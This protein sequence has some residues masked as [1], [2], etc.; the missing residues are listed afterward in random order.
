[1]DILPTLGYGGPKLR[2]RA[3]LRAA[4][5][6]TQSRI[7][8]KARAFKQTIAAKIFGLA[9]FLLLLT[10]GLAGFLLW[11]AARME[12]TI[13]IVAHL[14]LPLTDSISS[15]DEFGL[16]RRLAFERWFG[17]LNA[18]APNQEIISEAKT[19]YDS[20]TVK[21]TDEFATARRI[22]ASYP[23]AMASRPSLVEARTLLDQIE[24]AY[25]VISARQREVLDLQRS[26]QREKASA[27]LNPLNEMQRTVQ[28]QRELLQDKVAELSAASV[29]AVAL[30]QRYVLW[31][32]IAA[33]ASTVLLGLVVAALITDRLTQP[34]RSLASAIR[35]VQKGNLNVQ[36][37]VRSTD[38]VGALTDSFNFFVRELRDKEQIKQTF[39]KYVDVQQHQRLSALGTMAAGLAHELN[40]PASANLRAATQLPHTLTTLQIQTLK[41]C[42]EKLNREQLVF[43]GR[44]QTDLIGRADDADLD[45]LAQSDLEDTIMNWLD[46][47]QIADSWRLAPMLASAGMNA[48][49]LARIREQVGD[50]LLS[51]ALN[52]LESAVTIARL[53]HTLK[54]CSTRVSE[55]IK[56]FKAYTY[57]DQSPVQ[58]LDVHE[59]LENTLI[60]LRHKLKDI[61]IKR[62]YNRDLPRITAF[63]SALN[64]VWT[65]LLNNAAEALAARSNGTICLRTGQEND[66][67]VV[68]IADDGPGVP[69]ELQARLFEPFFT[70]KNVGQGTGLGL[71]IARR[72]VVERHH[73]TI[74][75]VS[76][77]GD[78]RFRVHLPLNPA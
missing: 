3:E 26:G 66:Y 55:L 56:V 61:V 36:V 53:S 13:K 49:E 70:T 71:S 52:W 17:A 44:L 2:N 77:P 59:G 25:R 75:V 21:S 72:I 11:E 32:T 60:V 57:M 7:W 18:T 40:N 27:L 24:P 69:T 54:R 4:M 46:D 45:P 65:I 5:E 28:T 37:P 41:L 58:E 47:A 43:L 74:S 62:V 67:I 15:I 76:S 29:Q 8:A 51:D 19:N 38:E 14:D 68:E 73:G 30:R 6:T 10:I 34:V 12:E 22:I 33:T 35:D 23:G 1:M 9:V 20:F 78:T 64:E 50:D 48:D 42:A 31:L 39:G 16:R 63:G